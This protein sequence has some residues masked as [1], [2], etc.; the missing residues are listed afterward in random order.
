MFGDSWLQVDLSLYEKIHC[1]L[2]L[3]RKNRSLKKKIDCQIKK[4]KEAAG[5]VFTDEEAQI[6][7]DDQNHSKI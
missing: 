6:D 3:V 2:C 4:K 7:V 5:Q 1:Q